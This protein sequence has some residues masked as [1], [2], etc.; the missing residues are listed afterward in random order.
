MTEEQ[1]LQRIAID[2]KVMIGKP[3]IRG[4]RLPVQTVVR[5]L[6]NGTTIEQL[7]TEYKGL[8]REDVL[9]CLLYAARCLDVTEV[10]PLAE[11]VN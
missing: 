4:T 10:V 6:A 11:T 3:V 1:L 7:L 5:R 2:P 8:E 9:A